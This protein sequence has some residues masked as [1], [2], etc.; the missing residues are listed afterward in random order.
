MEISYFD[1]AATTPLDP[2]VLEA[3][4]PY[5]TAQYGNPSSVHALG[6]RARFAVEEARE[7]VAAVL[8]CEPAEVV[9]TSGGTEANNLAIRG[10]LTHDDR[11][12]HALITTPVEHE[13]VLQPA[14]RLRSNGYPVTLLAPGPGGVV[15]AE[16]VQSA[17]TDATGLVSVMWVNN[18][19]GAVNDVAAMASACRRRG[20]PFHTDAVQAASVLPLA[21]DP[22]AVDLMSLSAHKFGGPKGAGVLYARQGTPLRP[23]LLG[24]AQ[25]RRRR[26]GTENVAAIVGLATALERAASRAAG[27]H[28]RLAALRGRLATG[29][30]EAFGN[31]LQVNSPADGAPH[32]LNV[33]FPPQGGRPVDGEMLLLALDMGGVMASSGSAC[34]SG[35]VE[36]SHVLRALD[37]ER[38]AARATVRLSMGRST[39]EASVDHAL[40]VLAEVVERARLA[41]SV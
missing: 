19:T 17:L 36:P 10:V 28:A 15:T 20:V 7:R 39:T 14:N 31:G 23:L 33:S 30:R 1:H 35:A 38:D 16:Q 37:V 25:E 22:L 32:I 9:F 8:S 3:M 13:A 21:V 4:M 11:R 24:G 26:G 27:E 29:L 2:V 34:A 40:A 18:E 5:L 41:V 12:G 6:R